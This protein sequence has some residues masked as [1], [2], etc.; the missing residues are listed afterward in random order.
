MG[1]Q[2]TSILFWF[3]EE[4]PHTRKRPPREE[5][6]VMSVLLVVVSKAL[7]DGTRF[8]VICFMMSQ[9]LRAGRVG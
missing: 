1:R 2:I 3:Q 6:H 4:H 7:E 9:H 5:G 8:E